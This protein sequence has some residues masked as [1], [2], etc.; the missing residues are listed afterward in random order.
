[1]KKQSEEPD[2]DAMLKRLHL[3]TVRRL[4]SELALRAETEDMSYRT[5]W[6]CPDSVDTLV[7]RG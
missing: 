5:Y 6:A 4:W 1:V 7:V 3:P 2:L